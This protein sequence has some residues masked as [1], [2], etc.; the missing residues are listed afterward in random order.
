MTYNSRNAV[1]KE[2]QEL[3]AAIDAVPGIK[4]RE[5]CCEHGQAH[6]W[7][8]FQIDSGEYFTRLLRCI[9]GNKHHHKWRVVVKAGKDRPH[10]HLEGPRGE[11][12][13]EEAL[14][15]AAIVR[16]EF[17][18]V[19]AEHYQGTVNALAAGGYIV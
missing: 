4:T 1:D 14:E 2:C 11:P 6:F 12:A 3:V 18:D 10:Y 19:P 5:S 17:S 7:I 9:D 16:S 15:L 8:W 13:Y